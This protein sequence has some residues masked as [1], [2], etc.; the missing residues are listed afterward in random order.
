MPLTPRPADAKEPTRMPPPPPPKKYRV[1]VIPGP[2]LV[3]SDGTRP[4]GDFARIVPED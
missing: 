3:F 1:E 4:R 2:A